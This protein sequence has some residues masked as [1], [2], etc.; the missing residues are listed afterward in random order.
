MRATD[1]EVGDRYHFDYASPPTIVQ[2]LGEHEPWTDPFGRDFFR[3]WARDES[4]GNEGWVPFGPSGV[5]REVT[6]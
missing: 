3:F 4:T 6:A 1:L 2:I 5:V